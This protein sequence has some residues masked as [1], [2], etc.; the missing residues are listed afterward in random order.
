M[1]L[2]LDK[3]LPALQQKGGV[4]CTE[5]R[6]L[7]ELVG[8]KIAVEFHIATYRLLT[9]NTYSRMNCLVLPKFLRKLYKGLPKVY[10]GELQELINNLT[11]LTH[12]ADYLNLSNERKQILAHYT[13]IIKEGKLLNR[14]QNL[15]HN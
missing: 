3:Y 1:R 2:T 6:A 8:I 11:N 10:I 5:K 15:I 9:P 4:K 7:R 12:I 14:Q 13:T